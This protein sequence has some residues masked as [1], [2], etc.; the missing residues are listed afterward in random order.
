MFMLHGSVL[1][2]FAGFGWL[3]DSCTA[4]RR[5]PGSESQDALRRQAPPCGAGDLSTSNRCSMMLGILQLSP[6][7]RV[8]QGS[9]ASLQ[10]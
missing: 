10:R 4:S 3:T 9:Q 2:P 5:L 7:Y 6:T 1:Q 8:Q